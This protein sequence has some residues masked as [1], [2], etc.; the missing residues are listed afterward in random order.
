MA[1]PKKKTTTSRRGNRRSHDALSN[2]VHI[3]DKNT[4]ERV[5][6]HHVC[7][8]TGMYRGQQILDIEE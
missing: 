7:R 5:R 8:T 2:P 4:G 6:P 3:E 1:V